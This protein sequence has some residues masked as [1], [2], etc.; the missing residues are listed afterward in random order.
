MNKDNFTQIIKQELFN[1][2]K[3]KSEIMEFIRGFVFANY[4]E[5]EF[6]TLN[7]TSKDTLNKLLDMFSALSIPVKCNKTQIFIEKDKIDLSNEI[8]IPTMFYAGVF[9]ASGSISDLNHSSYHLQISANYERCVDIFINKLNVYEFGFRKIQHN[10]K[11]VIYIKKHEKISDFL[12]AI[13]AFESMFKFEDARI[14]RDFDN[15]IN[16]INNVDVANIKKIVSTNQKHIKNYEYIIEKGLTNQFKDEQIKL[17]DLLS[18]N[19]EESMMW[20][21]SNLLEKYGIKISKSGVYLWLQMLDKLVSKH[22]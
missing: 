6:I 15:S 9:C 21:A 10:K 20:L 2:K 11:F 22:K 7:I 12:K 17:F 1:K 14:Q 8:K 18:K 5:N 3:N 4:I 13:C 16:R 19:P